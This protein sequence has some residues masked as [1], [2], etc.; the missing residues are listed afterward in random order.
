MIFL[1]NPIDRPTGPC[2]TTA[3]FDACINLRLKSNHLIARCAR[4]PGV[5]FDEKNIDPIF[6]MNCWY[7]M[8]LN[9]G[10]SR[11][12]EISTLSWRCK[13]LTCI[14]CEVLQLS[15]VFTS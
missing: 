13:T 10:I 9:P 11:M 3:M 14:K 2:N 12:M 6:I 4:C 8:K 15:C 1:Q 7:L 5:L